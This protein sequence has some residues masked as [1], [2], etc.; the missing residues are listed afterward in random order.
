[1]N[2]YA[3]HLFEQECVLFCTLYISL[4]MSSNQLGKLHRDRKDDNVGQNVLYKEM[5]I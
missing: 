3:F 4:N 1:M 5:L 2:L